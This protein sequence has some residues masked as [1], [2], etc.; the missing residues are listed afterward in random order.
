MEERYKQVPPLS[1]Y[2]KKYNRW[3]IFNPEERSCFQGGGAGNATYKEMQDFYPN[4][5]VISIEDAACLGVDVK[6]LI[7]APK[8]RIK[9]Y[10][11]AEEEAKAVPT[12]EE[13]SKIFPEG[14][15]DEPEKKSEKYIFKCTNWRAI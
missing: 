11:S 6:S 15:F 4:C 13:L 7:G 8:W 12:Y 1:K 14:F 9:E 2:P 10:D 3:L 5:V